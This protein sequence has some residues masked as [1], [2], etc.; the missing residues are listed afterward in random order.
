M[1][2]LNLSFQ[3]SVPFVLPYLSDHVLPYWAVV[4]NII[5]NTMVSYLNVLVE[6]IGVDVGA[7]VNHVFCSIH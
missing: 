2:H 7:V 4:P 5:N 6:R 1:T 3:F